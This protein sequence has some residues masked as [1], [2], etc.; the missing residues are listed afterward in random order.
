MTGA[1]QA[2]VGPGTR[3]YFAAKRHVGEMR[4]RGEL[5]EQA[6]CDFVR[7]GKFEEVN[8]ALSLLAD[9]PVDV[10]ERAVNDDDGEMMMLI[11]KA[12]GLSRPS[13]RL[14]FVRRTGDGISALDL[15]EALK[16]YAALSIDTARQVINFYRA[17]QG[18]PT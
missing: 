15:E 4:R 11:A 10:V 3:S 16:N 8:V 18:L 9:L 5:T 12:A 14:L 1:I 17:R 7:E 6:F 2:K 13:A